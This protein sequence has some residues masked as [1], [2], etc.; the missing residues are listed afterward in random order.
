[1]RGRP[2]KDSSR[3]WAVFALLIQL[4]GE[5]RWKTLKAKLNELGWSPNTLKQTLDAMEKDGDVTVSALRGLKGPEVWYSLT[6]KD[7]E[8]WNR[9]LNIPFK[10]HVEKA[11][12]AL[13][14][15]EGQPEKRRTYFRWTVFQLTAWLQFSQ[16]LAI[17]RAIKEKSF[18]N[19]CKL[20]TYIYE[21]T[22]KECALDFMKLLFDHPEL[23][24]D[25][26][27]DLVEELGNTLNKFA[28]P[29]SV[30][31]REALEGKP[32]EQFPV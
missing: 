19:T 24:A 8:T 22:L 21:A 31:V 2:V 3:K 28:Y 4:G 32:K 12:L 18:N 10:K 17:K 25:V 9:I 26:A 15:L 20:F 23:S 7:D 27:D 11:R 5:A 16:V 6:L 14:R 30:D 1:M 13:A 29:L